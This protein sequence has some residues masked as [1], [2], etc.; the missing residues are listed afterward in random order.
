MLAE[1]CRVLDTLLE[2]R[3][4]AVDPAA[5]A[6]VKKLYKV[7]NEGWSHL[8][9]AI[10]GKKIITTLTVKER[11]VAKL[12]AFGMSNPEIAAKLN[13]SLP[14]VKQAIRIT[15]EKTGMPRSQFAAIL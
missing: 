10:R 6:E 14:A 3:L 5:W 11:E 4:T 9:G 13:M 15:M 2:R 1:Y 7:Y 12:A 8:S